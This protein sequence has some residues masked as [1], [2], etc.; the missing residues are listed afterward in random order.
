MRV[1]PEP[2]EDHHEEDDIVITDGARFSIPLPAP[3][4][5]NIL[6]ISHDHPDPVGATATDNAEQGSGYEFAGLED[7]TSFDFHAYI[8]NLTPT[9]ANL[10]AIVNGRATPQRKAPRHFDIS[11]GH[12]QRNVVAGTR[13]RKLTYKVSTAAIDVDQLAA[14]L[15]HCFATSIAT[16]PSTSKPELSPG[17]TVAKQTRLHMYK[18]E[19]IVA[20]GE[21]YKS[22]DDKGTWED[23]TTLPSNVFA[24]PTSGYT[25]TSSLGTV[26]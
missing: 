18:E 5:P 22:H 16:T 9:E 19:W 14:H 11:A 8:D 23:V 17:P 21:E 25:N 13:T 15:D 12:D 4:F 20:E 7:N 3:F 10:Q 24:L 1:V 26:N 2:P 6:A